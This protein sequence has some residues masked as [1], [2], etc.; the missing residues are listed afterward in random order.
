[1]KYNSSTINPNNNIVFTFLSIMHYL[2][3]LYQIQLFKSKPF[4][5]VLRRLF[6]YYILISFMWNLVLHNLNLEIHSTMHSTD[7]H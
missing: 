7:M 3:H 5:C 4:I 2:K 1:M 6:L